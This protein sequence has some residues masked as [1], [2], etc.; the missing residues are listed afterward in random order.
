MTLENE[1][2]K[3]RG[4]KIVVINAQSAIKQ[5][6]LFIKGDG[7]HN[8]QNCIGAIN[9]LDEMKVTFTFSRQLSFNSTC[10][11]ATTAFMINMP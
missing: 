11:A 7:S 6:P 4:P 5:V 2:L 1:K 8:F 3:N 10:I 9:I